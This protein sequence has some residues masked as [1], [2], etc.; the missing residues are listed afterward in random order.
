MF[1]YINKD[2]FFNC[3]ENG[4]A[5]FEEFIKSETYN[6]TIKRIE[7]F[8]LETAK[9]L[10]KLQK[11][12]EYTVKRLTE[13]L[14]Q[15]RPYPDPKIMEFLKLYTPELQGRTSVGIDLL[16]IF[17]DKLPKKIS[18]EEVKKMEPGMSLL[19]K[20]YIS[21]HQ[22]FKEQKSL[23]IDYDQLFKFILEL[24]TKANKEELFYDVS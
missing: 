7:N 22:L 20:F 6:K 2:E 1:D 24:N 18:K 5:K 15:I 12:N 10:S 14:E 19:W 17:F 16:N 8:D 4:E 9:F 13:S 3:L 11:E 23:K 21:E